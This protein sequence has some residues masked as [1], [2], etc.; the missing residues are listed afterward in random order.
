MNAENQKNELKA[1]ETQQSSNP[2]VHP[3]YNAQ[4]YPGNPYPNV[5]P[6]VIP[7][8]ETRDTCASIGCSIFI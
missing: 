5:H 3:Y 8:D 2:N 1:W 6:N 4:P 7:N